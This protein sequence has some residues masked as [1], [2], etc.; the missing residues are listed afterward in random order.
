MQFKES[1]VLKME[2]AKLFKNVLGGYINHE[3]CLSF[4]VVID[5]DDMKALYCGS[6]E[7]FMLP[8]F[9]MEDFKKSIDKRTVKKSQ[10]IGATKLIVFV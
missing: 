3:C 10:M 8:Q 7:A 9:T 5:T 6:V 4:L 1:E 2:K